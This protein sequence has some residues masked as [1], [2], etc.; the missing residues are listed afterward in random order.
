M[1]STDIEIIEQLREDGRKS[2]SEIAGELGLATSTVSARVSKLEDEGIIQN[3]K[4]VIDYE[5]AGF[6]LTAII[7][8]CARAEKI[9]EVAEKVESSEKVIS[10]FEVT[11]ET[12]MIVAARFFDR[13]DMNTTIKEF[14]KVE[15]IESTD[16]HIVLT[17][18]TLEGEID[19]S[20]ILDRE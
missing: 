19:L 11:G 20:S 17:S 14:Q 13:E 7:D 10:F 12:D 16:T 3:Y 8:I 2:F 18:P 1:D 15:G 4:P 5:E 6:K 9:E